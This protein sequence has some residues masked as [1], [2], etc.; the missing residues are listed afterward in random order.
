MGSKSASLYTLAALTGGICMFFGLSTIVV[1]V[2]AKRKQINEVFFNNYLSTMHLFKGDDDIDFS[3]ADLF[4]K[5][6]NYFALM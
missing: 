6:S 5:N 3:L 2:C 1:C 4:A